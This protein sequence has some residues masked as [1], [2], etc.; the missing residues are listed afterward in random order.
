MILL[1]Y[2]LI[3]IKNAKSEC[4]ATLLNAVQTLCGILLVISGE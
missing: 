2:Y 1:V 3:M 4:D